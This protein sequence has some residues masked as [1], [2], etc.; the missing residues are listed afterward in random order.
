MSKVVDNLL[1]DNRNYKKRKE[2]KRKKRE[3]ESKA[4]QENLDNI[5]NDVM[6][7]EQPVKQPNVFTRDMRN[8]LKGMM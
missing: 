7:K 1:E 8:R 6:E 3:E 4:K 2:E 5:Q